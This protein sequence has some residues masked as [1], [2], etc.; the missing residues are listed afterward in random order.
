VTPRRA[1]HR[2]G[3]GTSAATTGH[4]GNASAPARSTPQANGPVKTGHD[5]SGRGALSA[6]SRPGRGAAA[7]RS[8]HPVAAAPRPREPVDAVPTA[9]SCPAGGVA[10]VALARTTSPN[11][12]V[13]PCAN[14][15]A[16]GPDHARA[17]A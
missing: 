11:D 10:G 7:G 13:G 15:P 8:G 9:V 1:S 12:S 14:L 6:T 3:A 2:C 16:V 17:T 5:V 4:T